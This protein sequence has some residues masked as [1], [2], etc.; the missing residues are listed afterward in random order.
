MEKMPNTKA[1]AISIVVGPELPLKSLIN[2]KGHGK[3]LLESDLDL[4]FE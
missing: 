2:E 1:S 3:I 4:A